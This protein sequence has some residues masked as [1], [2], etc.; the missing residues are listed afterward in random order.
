MLDQRD[1]VAIAGLWWMVAEAECE[2]YFGE[3][4]ERYRFS[5]ETVFTPKVAESIRYCLERIS[6]AQVWNVLWY[7]MRDIAALLQEGKYIRP[8]VYN[9]VAGNIRR[10]IDR[11]LANNFPIR[12]WNRL[13]ADKEPII[14]G[15]FFDKVLGK[16]DFAFETVT[17]RN[18][19]NFFHD[20]T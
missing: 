4:C 7:T 1:L 12:P 19:G 16:G 10:D 5:R 6:L 2:R 13:R 9:M 17:A 18:I 20:A 15:I 11:R 14:T 3:L 8:H